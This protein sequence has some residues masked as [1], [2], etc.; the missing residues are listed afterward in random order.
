MITE[1]NDDY[2]SDIVTVQRAEPVERPATFEKSIVPVKPKGSGPY[3]TY[4][5]MGRRRDS[6]AKYAGDA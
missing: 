1:S 5:G 3:R 6:E 4:I 2:V